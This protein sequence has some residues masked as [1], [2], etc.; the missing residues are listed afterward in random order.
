MEDD[1]GALA[2]RQA[3]Q[4]LGEHGGHL[5]RVVAGLGGHAAMPPSLLE[6]PRGDAVGRTPDPAFRLTE[7][8]P[9]AERLR[10][11]FRDRVVGDGCV[12]R[13]GQQAS[14]QPSGMGA[15][16]GFDVVDGLRGLE[17]DVHL[18]LQGRGQPE[19]LHAGGHVVGVGRSRLLGVPG[20]ARHG[21]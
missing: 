11:G 8:V 12:T 21:D 13:V 3:G 18:P 17:R 10:E 1:R 19:W 14:P 5:F 4:R 6:R 7:G 15:V 9:P 2:G 20:L 16:D